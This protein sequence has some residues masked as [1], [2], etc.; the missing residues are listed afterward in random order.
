[1]KQI[2]QLLFEARSLNRL[3]RSGYQFLGVGRESVAEHSFST[4]FI[5]Y[6]LSHM[7][8]E[9]DA[10]KLITM[11]LVH[12]L[13][14]ARVGDLNY[15]Q[16]FYLQADEGA[17]LDDMVHAL[18]FGSDLRALID[19]FNQGAS[20]EARLAHDAD[21]LAFLLELKAL[22]DV[23]LRH[24]QVLVATDD[25]Y[26]HIYW[27]DEPFVTFAA[28]CPALFDRTVTVNGVSKA[29]AMTGWRIG[30][31]GGPAELVKG[32]KK[33]QGQSTSNPTSIAQYA[34]EA[35]LSGDQSFLA[36]MCDVFRQR[37]DYVYQTLNSMSGVKVLPSDGTFYSFPSFHA[38][39][40]RMDGIDSDVKLAEFILDKAEVALVPGSAFGQHTSQRRVLLTN[41]HVQQG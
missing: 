33:I 19:E 29:Y 5:A 14:E 1:M 39:I 21:Q 12:D 10:R 3:P 37:H 20:L 36:E 18:P 15:V 6:V 24:P 9:A 7:V 34:S 26:E 35:A 22:A 16:K 11:S 32:M 38:V 30:Y 28:A 23:L 40:E 8:P 25:M 27:A 41:S 13:P 4:T 2:A 31:C 17:A